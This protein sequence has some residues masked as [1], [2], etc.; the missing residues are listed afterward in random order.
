MTN[1]VF[2][3]LN[4]VPIKLFEHFANAFPKSSFAY[5]LSRSNLYETYT[6]DVGDLSPWISWPTL[7]RGVSNVDHNISDLGQNL[8]YTDKYFPPVWQILDN[9]G[10]KV[11]LF[12][13][14]Q[15]YPVPFG[16]SNYSFYVPDT[17]AAGPE[18]IPSHFDKFQKFNLGMTSVNGRNVVS[19]VL[20]RE[21]ID[22][23][24]TAPF[25]GLTGETAVR[26][27]YQLISE[28]F[29][30]SRIVR[31]RS[32]QTEIAFDLFFNLLKKRKPQISFFFTN[33][34]A[35]SM[36]RYWP[37]IFPTDYNESKFDNE[38]LNSWRNEIPHSIRV[39]DRQMWKLIALCNQNNSRLVVTSS[40][41]Q[42]AVDGSELISSQVLIS[43]VSKLFEFLGISRDEWEPRLSMAPRVVI[44]PKYETFK[45]KI[46]MLENLTVNGA[47]ISMQNL[48]TGDFC[49]NVFLF[50]Q[51]DLKV[52]F[53]GKSVDP[54][55]VGIKN[56]DLQDAAGSNA[57]HIPEGIL[58]DYNSQKKFIREIKR[59]WQKI[60]VL[61]VAPSILNYFGVK[62]L[63]H[64]QSDNSIFYH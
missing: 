51:K 41:G 36:H 8:Q 37:T 56:V 57:Y 38:W 58:I 16:G 64:M 63:N 14:L 30:A 4:E 61:E 44:R 47:P 49:F 52:D 18:T 59:N 17:F 26:L 45:K 43:N 20:L 11:G 19:Q 29:N 32:S 1:L 25:I 33:H 42:A 27:A 9:S 2:Y 60:S 55:H 10:V 13:S 46:S 48:D 35:S 24:R 53:K 3:E 7:H 54:S 28:K 40:M 50:N 39:A 12:G 23:V 5:L 62:S 6:A 22:F 21:A 34:L 15:S 31:R